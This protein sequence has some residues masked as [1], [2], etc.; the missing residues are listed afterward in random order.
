M[1][2]ELS[3]FAVVVFLF[4]AN[5]ISEHLFSWWARNTWSR[6]E[7][8]VSIIVLVYGVKTFMLLAI[9]NHFLK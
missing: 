5:I 8:D 9:L 2:I 1:T 6:S 7:G 4:A 3:V